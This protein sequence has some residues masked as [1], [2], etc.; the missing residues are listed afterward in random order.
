MRIHTL[1]RA[2]QE[3]RVST[4]FLLGLTNTPTPAAELERQL[5]ALRTQ[6]KT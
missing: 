3:L 5:A 6:T 2:A 4:D 1:K